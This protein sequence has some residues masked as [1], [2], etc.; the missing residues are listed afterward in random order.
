MSKTKSLYLRLVDAGIPA[1]DL[2]HH[3]SDLY[4]TVS[5]TTKKIVEGFCKEM[6]MEMPATFKS[7]ETP[8]RRTYDIPFAYDPFWDESQAMARPDQS[9]PAS[10]YYSLQREMTAA[11]K[12]GMF[13]DTMDG[14]EAKDLAVHMRD[15]RVNYV[16]VSVASFL[17][18]FCGHLAKYWERKHGFPIYVLLDRD[19]L[20]H[21]FNC[22][23]TMDGR[24]VFLDARGATTNLEEFAAPFCRTHLML[25]TDGKDALEHVPDWV[26]P[27]DEYSEAM[28]SW[29]LRRKPCCYDFSMLRAPDAGHTI[30]LKEVL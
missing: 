7:L 13:I 8:A 18:G 24:T 1:E 10:P 27:E 16:T 25:V 30:N 29:L 20:V 22:A 12:L 14:I 26:F 21:V 6:G 28:I 3:A 17:L 19:E 9:L 5:P 11:G 15:H 2:D 4:V 23:I